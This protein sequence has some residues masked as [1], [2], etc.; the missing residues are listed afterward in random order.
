VAYSQSA[1]AVYT[2][3]N[4]LY[5]AN[6]YQGAQAAY[7]KLIADGYKEADLYYNLGNCYYRQNDMAK[8]ILNYERALR[9][10]P[11][12]EDISHNLNI[13][14]AHIADKIVPV[15][16]LGI[17][18]AWQGFMHSYSA[19]GWLLWA[20]AM[21]WLA[22]IGGTM[23]LFTTWKK[24]GAGIAATFIFIT[25]AFTSLA[26]TRGSAEANSGEAILTAESI[27]VKNAPDTNSGNA[28]MLH[29]GVK[30]NL[31]D[32]VGNYYKVRLADGKTGWLSSNSFEQI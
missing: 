9:I 15:P 22:L 12:D 32:K 13:A 29:A 18:K 23:F 3:A 8:A 31:L 19:Q 25:V 11:N 14:N 28:F 17:I 5:K 6:D 26:Y 16:Q 2:N 21:A 10:S 30:F 1:D 24:T 4:V 7:E 20:I 27:Y